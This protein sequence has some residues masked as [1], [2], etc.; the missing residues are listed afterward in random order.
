M[1]EGE[2][3]E[4]ARGVV[5]WKGFFCSARRIGEKS[6][7]EL[8][9]AGYEHFGPGHVVEADLADQ[10]SDGDRTEGIKLGKG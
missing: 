1:V 6:T 5:R 7:V 9:E 3:V 8:V 2:T 10:E 4:A